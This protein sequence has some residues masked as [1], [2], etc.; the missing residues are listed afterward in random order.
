MSSLRSAAYSSGP[1]VGMFMTMETIVSPD[2]SVGSHSPRAVITGLMAMRTACLTVTVRS[3]SPLARSAV[4]YGSPITSSRL[5]R[6]TRMMLAVP[7]VPI[8]ITAIH[9][10]LRKST[11]FSQLHGALRSSGENRPPTGK[12]STSSANTIRISARKKL[13]ID[14]PM[15]PAKVAMW[16]EILFLCNAE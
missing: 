16:S 5:P 15:K 12:S 7:A 14:S 9:T 1:A 13:G 6:T 4:M 8:T 2:I 11:S 3:G 10:C